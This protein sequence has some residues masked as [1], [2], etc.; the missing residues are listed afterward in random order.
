MI[1]WRKNINL[2]GQINCPFFN[3]AYKSSD[4]ILNNDRAFKNVKTRIDLV[5]QEVHFISANGVA[6]FMLMGTE[7]EMSYADTTEKGIVQYKF[8]TGY[9]PIDR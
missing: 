3:D 9:P 1:R 7:K 2:I 6:A 5:T 4:I 8:Q